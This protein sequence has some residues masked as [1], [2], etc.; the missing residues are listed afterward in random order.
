MLGSLYLVTMHGTLDL[1]SGA[2]GLSLGFSHKEFNIIAGVD[3]LGEAMETF[4]YN[5]A[6]V[7]LEYN[8]AERSPDELCRPK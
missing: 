8:L 3:N 7:G 4:R 5:H 1:F 6:S 2:G